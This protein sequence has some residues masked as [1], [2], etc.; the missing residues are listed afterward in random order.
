MRNFFFLP[1]FLLIG[2]SSFCVSPPESVAFVITIQKSGHAIKDT[3][4]KTWVNDFRTFRDAL[5]KND[6]AAIKSFF[7]FPLLNKS[8]DIWYLV[9]TEK[10]LNTKKI[11]AGKITPFTE[12]DFHHYYKKIFPAAFVKCLLKIKSDRLYRQ[13]AVETPEFKEGGAS[14]VKMYAAFDKKKIHLH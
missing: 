5:Y 2:S 11:S 7:K 14:T 10:E 12:K 13:E 4:T 9:L 1:V 3:N 6:T 8:N